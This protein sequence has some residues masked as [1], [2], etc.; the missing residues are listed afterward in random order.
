MSERIAES[1]EFLD[2]IAHVHTD[3]TGARINP[4][5]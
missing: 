4:A 5:Q 3:R 1:P 2:Y